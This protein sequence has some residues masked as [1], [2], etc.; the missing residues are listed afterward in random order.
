M[1]A[2]EEVVTIPTAASAYAYYGEND[3]RKFDLVRLEFSDEIH[4]S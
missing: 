4:S 1:T 2:P 3:T